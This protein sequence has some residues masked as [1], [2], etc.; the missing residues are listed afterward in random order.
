MTSYPSPVSLNLLDCPDPSMFGRFTVVATT[1]ILLWQ[2]LGQFKPPRSS[3]CIGR[4]E[5]NLKA[6]GQPLAILAILAAFS[7]WTTPTHGQEGG[8]TTLP[9][10][11]SKKVDWYISL[12]VLG[13]LPQ[14]KNLS[15]GGTVIQNTSIGGAVGAGVK[16]GLFPSF[17]NK[18]IGFEIETFGHGGSVK[19]PPT[20][21]L[22]SG[23][24][25]AEGN[26]VL[27]N[28][29]VNLL[30]RYPG[31]ILQPYVGIGGGV[32]L[33]VLSDVNIQQG[34]DLLT[35]SAGSGAFAYQF[36]GGLRANVSKRVFLFGEYKY[37]VAEHEWESEGS[38]PSTSLNYHT[39]IIS[40]GVGLS[41]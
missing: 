8:G 7:L 5:D 31:E 3:L 14:D 4:Q 17:T 15:V 2:A 40:G 32:S 21:S 36:L 34:N 10:P 35:G 23:V 12:Y 19:A 28:T 24:T 39:Q 6:K 16:A 13:T 26:L 18:I 41:F 22:S 27:L 25:Q 38:G 20:T 11:P 33:G 1:R 29:M 37:F 9:P 30:A